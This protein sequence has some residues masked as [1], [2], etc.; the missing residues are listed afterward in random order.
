MNAIYRY[1]ESKLNININWCDILYEYEDDIYD[2]DNYDKNEQLRKR[3]N[4]LLK[5]IKNLS[6]CDNPASNGDDARAMKS[7][8]NNDDDE[9]HKDKQIEEI[10]NMFMTNDYSHKSIGILSPNE[11]QTQVTNEYYKTI[12]NK[13]YTIGNIF[14]F[15]CN[16]VSTVDDLNENDIILPI[17]SLTL[18]KQDVD[19]IDVSKI[20]FPTVHN[21]NIILDDGNKY[22][23]QCYDFIHLVDNFVK[24]DEIIKRDYAYIIIPCENNENQHE[25]SKPDTY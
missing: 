3:I 9:H 8:T 6:W 4:K 7:T 25:Q 2:L 18:S 21:Y 14:G 12:A 20:M 16:V 23:K 15:T 10:I 5:K 17:S 24:H 1:C 19:K 13:V 11:K 22:N